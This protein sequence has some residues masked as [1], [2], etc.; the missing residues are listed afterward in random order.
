MTLLAQFFLMSEE[1]KWCLAIFLLQ[2]PISQLHVPGEPP[3][4]GAGV[5]SGVDATIDTAAVHLARCDLH[6]IP[7]GNSAGSRLDRA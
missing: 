5:D 4:A 2:C 1:D 6:F 3:A 7:H